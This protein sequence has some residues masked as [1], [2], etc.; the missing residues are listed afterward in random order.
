MC[1]LYM[2]KDMLEHVLILLIFKPLFML[3]HKIY[4][5]GVSLGEIILQTGL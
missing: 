4:L 2:P 1:L 5:I 3:F